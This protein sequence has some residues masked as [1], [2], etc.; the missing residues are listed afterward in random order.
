MKFDLHCHTAEGSS[1]SKVSI[2]EY[3]RLLKEQGYDGMMVTDHDSYGGYKYYLEHKEETPDDFVVLKSIEYD[4][5][6]AGHFLVVMPDGVDLEILEYRGLG[7]EQLEEIVHRYGGI[8]GPAH[9]CGEPFLS[10]F[11]TGKYKRDRS[12]LKDFDFLEG[13]NCGEDSWAND[14]AVELAKE[15]GKPITSGSDAHWEKCVGLAYTIIEGDVKNND[16]FIE[17]IRLGKSTVIW[18]RPYDGTLKARLGKWN[19]LLVYGFFPYN[20]FGALRFA[21]KRRR[22]LKKLDGDREN[23]G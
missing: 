16:D 18:G 15:F 8:L 10:I 5:S 14:E 3:I 22:A 9:P 17:Y 21:L 12:I 23:N 11:S 20:K 19:K 6:D 13:F 2:I 1:D 7:I 4:T